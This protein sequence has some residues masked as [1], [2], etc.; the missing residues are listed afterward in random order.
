[1]VLTAYSAMEKHHGALEM[2]YHL[3]CLQMCPGTSA[4]GSLIEHL[5]NA[6]VSTRGAGISE[7]FGV[8]PHKIPLFVLTSFASSRSVCDLDIDESGF[9]RM[10]LSP[11]I[12][13][14]CLSPPKQPSDSPVRE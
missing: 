11:E 14:A 3:Q 5:T 9:V 12:R 1:M 7:Y 13:L 2:S 4:R 6:H 10:V 8:A